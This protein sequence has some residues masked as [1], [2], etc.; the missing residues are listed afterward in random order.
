M[1]KPDVEMKEATQKNDAESEETQ[2]EVS[3]EEK[4]RLVLE[5]R[6]KMCF[7]QLF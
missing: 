2:A 6:P 5:G 4:E 1:A 3:K 7:Y